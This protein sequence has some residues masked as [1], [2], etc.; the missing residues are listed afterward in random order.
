M[1][2]RSCTTRTTPPSRAASAT[3]CKQANLREPRYKGVRDT[4]PTYWT[5]VPSSKPLAW[6]VRKGVRRAG[7]GMW[8]TPCKEYGVQSTDRYFIQIP[9]CLGRGGRFCSWGEHRT[10]PSA[11]SVCA[12]KIQ[13]AKKSSTEFN[14]FSCHVFCRGTRNKTQ[15]DWRRTC[16]GLLSVALALGEPVALR[17]MLLDNR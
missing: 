2:G 8:R 5:H 17:S 7:C 6:G 11:C 1:T 4:R 10:G 3:G 12:V 16:V 13:E 14:Q 9:T 15:I